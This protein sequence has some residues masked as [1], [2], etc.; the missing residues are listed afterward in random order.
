MK[1]LELQFEGKGK[2][3]GT[4]FKQLSK[5]EKAFMYELTDKETGSKRYEVFERKVSKASEVIFAGQTVKYEEKEIYPNSNC[6]GN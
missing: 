3:S 4:I 6:F 5:H 2:V 1:T